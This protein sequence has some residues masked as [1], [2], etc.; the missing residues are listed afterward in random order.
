MTPTELKAAEQRLDELIRAFQDEDISTEVIVAL[1]T[2]R[3]VMLGAGVDEETAIRDLTTF[4][5][6][7]AN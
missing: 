3:A 2:T 7:V 5:R 6:R 1:L 4:G